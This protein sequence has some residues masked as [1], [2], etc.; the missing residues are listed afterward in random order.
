MR[1]CS[2]TRTSCCAAVSDAFV[3]LAAYLRPA[4]REPAPEPPP[5]AVQEAEIEPGPIERDETLRAARLFRAGLADALDAAVQRLL[6]AIARD[7]L[8]RELR[9]ESADVAAIVRAALFRFDAQSVLLVRVH[10][11]DCDALAGLE[12]KAI[13]DDALFPGDVCLELQSGTINLTLAARLDA[14]LAA[15]TA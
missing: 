15:W 9:L 6:P 11:H 10:P 13:A 12:L 14:A 1:R 4:A 7:V 5:A 8:A 3:P 2:R